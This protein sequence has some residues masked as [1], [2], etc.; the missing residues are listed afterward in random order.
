MLHAFLDTISSL[1]KR[2]FVKKKKKSLLITMSIGLGKSFFGQI[3]VIANTF[4]KIIDEAYPF[5]LKNSLSSF[6]I[7]FPLMHFIMPIS[8]IGF[9][10]WHLTENCVE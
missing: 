10:M 9:W 7:Y 4:E 8:K 5:F 6:C 1:F 3:F 2:F